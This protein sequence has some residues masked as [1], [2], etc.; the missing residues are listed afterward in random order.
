M[1]LKT[2][3][4]IKSASLLKWLSIV[5]DLATILG[6]SVATLV[7]GPFLGNLSGLGFDTAEFLWAVFFYFVYILALVGSSLFF[8]RLTVNYFKNSIFSGAISLSALVL[9]WAIWFSLSDSLESYFGTLTGSRY[10]LVAKPQL[11]IDK[12]EN[13]EIMEEGSS[14]FIKGKVA[15]NSGYVPS[16]YVVSLYSM[17][18]DTGE[19]EYR[20]VGLNKTS[21]NI[22]ADGWFSLPK[23]KVDSQGLKKSYL[24][25]YRLSDEGKYMGTVF[26][27]KL[28]QVPS[29]SMERLGAVVERLDKWLTNN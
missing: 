5:S 18:T 13:I 7:A 28:T 23:V 6:V 16:D 24:A 22:N 17:N 11:A 9:S 1:F 8:V 27:N 29:A 26:P 3:E 20:Y 14:T 4:E 12:F 25:I 19:Y 10:M 21:S 15:L 2:Y